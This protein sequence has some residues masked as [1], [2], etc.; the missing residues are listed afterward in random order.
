MTCGPARARRLGILRDVE[1]RKWPLAAISD[2]DL[3]TWCD[4]DPQ[5]RYP[6]MAQVIRIYQQA[7][8][9]APPRWTSTALRFLERAPDR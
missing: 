9:K 3:I 8:D 4:Q 1:S 7:G 6:A 5:A 2:D